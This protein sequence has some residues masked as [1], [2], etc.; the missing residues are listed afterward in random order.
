MSRLNVG[1]LF[2][3]NEDGAPVVSGIS[4][5]SSPHYFVPP[6]GSTAQ[7]PQNPGEGMIRFNTDSGHLEYYTGTHW[8]DVIVN[9]QDLGDHNNSN[10]TGGTGTRGIQAGGYNPSPLSA[11]HNVIQYITIETLGNAQDFGDLPTS[12]AGPRGVASR[13]RGLRCGG[14]AAPTNS[15]NNTIEFIT[16]ASTGNGTDFGDLITNH[17]NGGATGNQTRGVLAAASTPSNVN[18][19]EYIT[20]AAEGNSVDFGDIVS[21]RE[22]LA[23]GQI[24]SAVRGIFTG[25][26]GPAPGYT[27]FNT[28]E[29]VT[30]STTG[31]A[32]DFGDLTQARYRPAAMCSSTRGA[33]AGGWASPGARVNT[34]DF[35][36]IATLGNALDFGDAT[37]LVQDNSGT[38]SP[39]RG[40]FMGGTTPSSP[41][42]TNTIEYITIAQT[43][44]ALDFGDLTLINGGGFA[45]SNG[46]GGL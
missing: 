6:S 24:N 46:H 30:I 28:I 37:Q 18:I 31:N 40:V 19:I 12:A 36:T 38:S 13:T 5:F 9:N 26:Y 21:A 45:I 7:R 4:T 14:G 42:R 25:G 44:N 3:E 32:Q 8:A 20:I 34:I 27:I 35:I 22:H 43:G 15:P 1:N 41:N 2:N 39:T 16:I 33:L 17:K 10:S 23:N 29:Y 11:V